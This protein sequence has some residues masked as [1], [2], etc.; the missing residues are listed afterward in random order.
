LYTF[1]HIRWNYHCSWG[2]NVLGFR[3]LPL[4]TNLHPHEHE[5]ISSLIFI[6]SL[7]I[8]LSISYP[9][10]Y[11]PIKKNVATHEHWPPRIKMIPQNAFSCDALV[12][13]LMTLT[14]NFSTKISI[15]LW[16]LLS[17]NFC[18]MLK[19]IRQQISLHAKSKKKTS[20]VLDLVLNGNFFVFWNITWKISQFLKST[21]YLECH[22][23]FT[24]FTKSAYFKFFYN[25]Y[26]TINYF[27]K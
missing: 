16:I 17:H 20:L 13:N 19:H 24:Y 5:F 21:V 15:I 26:C 8:K 1:F 10:I 18:K 27:P 12:Y 23:L 4:H 9:R 7:Q 6:N 11:I 3:G 25:S 2:T 14:W 22:T